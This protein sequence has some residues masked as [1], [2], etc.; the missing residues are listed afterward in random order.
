MNY[1]LA[2][3]LDR[4]AY[5]ADKTEIID[6]D[7]IDPMSQIQVVYECTGASTATFQGHPALCITKIELVDGSDVLFSLS[8]KEAQVVDFYHNKVVP[9]NLLYYL[10]GI[11]AEQIFNINFGRFLYDPRLALDPKQFKNLQLKISVDYNGGGRSSAGGYL[12]VLAHL[13]DEKQVTPEGFF[14]AKEIKTYTLAAST[15]EYTDLP[16]DH[17]Y[18]KLFLAA[19]AY[20]YYPDVQVDTIKLSQDVDKKVPFNQSMRQ[21]IRAIQA[22]TPPWIEH[23]H[24]SCPAAGGDVNYITPT[25][26]VGF[27]LTPWDVPASATTT[28]AADYGDGGRARFSSTSWIGNIQAIIR[29]WLPHG[30]IEIPF[31]LQDDPEDWFDP[32]SIKNLKLDVKGGA[33]LGSG[34]AQIF[35]QQLRRY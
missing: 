10:N 34:T 30:G 2:T 9:P 31:G 18:R 12:S 27:A 16:T 23:L 3:L 17:P 29:G 22:L 11:N 8:G 28:L 19:Q 4:T 21:I 7:V 1:R 15:H 26:E 20:G 25:Y 14:M 6:I 32:S 35:L 24:T 33:S 13:F 5:A